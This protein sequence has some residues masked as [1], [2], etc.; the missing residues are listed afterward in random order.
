MHV[1]CYHTNDI[2]EI[3]GTRYAVLDTNETENPLTLSDKV[4]EWKD[5]HPNC[6]I[7]HLFDLKTDRIECATRGNTTSTHA[8]QA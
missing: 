4:R 3:D 5:T 8:M 1:L 2:T 6:T 7:D